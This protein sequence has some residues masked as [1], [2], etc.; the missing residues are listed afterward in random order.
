MSDLNRLMAGKPFQM[1][2]IVIDG[3]QGSSQGH[4]RE[5]RVLTTAFLDSDET[6]SNLSGITGVPETFVIDRKDV[7]I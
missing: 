4:Y 5:V 6:I 1:Q 7:T 2:A 3:W